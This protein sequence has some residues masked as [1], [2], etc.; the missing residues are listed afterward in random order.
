MTENNELTEAVQKL[1]QTVQTM[2]IEQYLNESLKFKTQID[3]ALI[4]ITNFC[5]AMQHTKNETLSTTESD[6][7]ISAELACRNLIDL[8]TYM[9]AYLKKKGVI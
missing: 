1:Q 8:M 7:I 2:T 5:S 6:I 9:S 4:I 3:S